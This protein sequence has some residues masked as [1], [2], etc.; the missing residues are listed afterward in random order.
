MIPG[1]VTNLRLEGERFLWEEPEFWEKPCSFYQ[2]QFE[3]KRVQQG[4]SCQA[5]PALKE[6]GKLHRVPEALHPGACS[7]WTRA[8]GEHSSSLVCSNKATPCPT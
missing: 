5:F 3:V 7:V 8:R 4:A 6:V 2:L 1:R